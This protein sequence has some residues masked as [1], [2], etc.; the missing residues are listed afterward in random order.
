M[1]MLQPKDMLPLNCLFHPDLAW[2][3]D[4]MLTVSEK[5]GSFSFQLVNAS[6]FK[7][8]HSKQM[9][10]VIDDREHLRPSGWL[11]QRYPAPHVVRLSGGHLLPP[12][13]SRQN[14]TQSK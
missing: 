7:Q 14:C 11:N 13:V 4:F 9:H 6:L 2:L 10:W 1:G 12:P 3:S 8:Q 5:D